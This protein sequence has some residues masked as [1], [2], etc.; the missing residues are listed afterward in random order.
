[1]NLI[2]SRPDYVTIWLRNEP[3]NFICNV[4][5][6][7]QPSDLKDQLSTLP[8]KSEEPFSDGEKTLTYL[9]IDTWEDIFFEQIQHISWIFLEWFYIL[10]IDTIV[11]WNGM[12]SYHPLNGETTILLHILNLF[13]LRNDTNKQDHISFYCQKI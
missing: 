2:G 6:L 3:L 4:K 10:L 13:P 9:I 5:N 1:M 11:I 7:L 12:F 8:T